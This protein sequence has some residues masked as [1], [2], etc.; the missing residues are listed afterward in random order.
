MWVIKEDENG[1]EY[2][3]ATL[4]NYDYFGGRTL[5]EK[6]PN[7]ATIVAKGCSPLEL[8]TLSREDFQKLGFHEKLKFARRPAIYEGRRMEEIIAEPR[9]LGGIRLEESEEMSGG[10]ASS[11]IDFIVKA[12]KKNPNLRNLTDKS[13]DEA[14]RKMAARARRVQVGPDLEI[15]VANSLGHEFFIISQGSFDLFSNVRKGKMEVQSAEAV[16]TSTS[17][18]ERLV[19]K[20][21]FLLDMLKEKKVDGTAGLAGR[22]SMLPTTNRQNQK[23]DRGQWT[24]SS[25]VTKKAARR[26]AVG[27]VVRK[28]TRAS[29]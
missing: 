8:L 2:E 26:P 14:I 19:R 25:L 24:A 13:D 20:Q 28:G 18:T 3:C 5:T 4:Y 9:R 1:Y 7:V 29:R 12:I 10:L 22:M 21:Q 15:A 11:E 6:R 23:P 16:Y 17:M 27:A